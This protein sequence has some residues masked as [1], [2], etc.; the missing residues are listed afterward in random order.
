MHAEHGGDQVAVDLGV[1]HRHQ[2]GA[3]PTDPSVDVFRAKLVDER[4]RFAP[5]V[6]ACNNGVSGHVALSGLCHDT[7]GTGGS[8]PSLKYMNL[9]GEVN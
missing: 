2:H 1:Y 4:L 3:G 6:E 8:V 7:G 9:D 5:G